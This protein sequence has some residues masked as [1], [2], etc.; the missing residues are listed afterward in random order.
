MLV[1]IREGS[2]GDRARQEMPSSDGRETVMRGASGLLQL[3]SE[4]KHLFAAGC[5]YQAVLG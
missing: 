1:D 5:L 4:D 2:G 3:K